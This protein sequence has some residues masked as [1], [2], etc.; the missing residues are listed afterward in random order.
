ML[1]EEIA[2]D[3]AHYYMMSLCAFFAYQLVPYKCKIQYSV[4]GN[5]E[6][7]VSTIPGVMRVLAPNTATDFQGDRVGTE[8]VTFLCQHFVR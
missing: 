1:R 4:N 8:S 6:G 2:N 7:L 5:Y 3:N